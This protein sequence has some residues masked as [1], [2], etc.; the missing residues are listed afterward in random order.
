MIFSLVQLFSIKQ[1]LTLFLQCVRHCEKYQDELDV[2]LSVTGLYSKEGS[3][4]KYTIYPNAL[5]RLS[6]MP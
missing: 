1:L 6:A 2:D 4:D 5:N 3:Y